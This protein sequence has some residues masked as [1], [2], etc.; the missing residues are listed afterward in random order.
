[1]KPGLPNSRRNRPAKA[2][3]NHQQR[4]KAKHEQV[5][6]KTRSRPPVGAQAAGNLY[7]NRGR[8]GCGERQKAHQGRDGEVAE[9]CARGD[10]GSGEG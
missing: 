7:P 4:R 5:S 10:T 6:Q 2:R 3:P 9:R 8:V 1:M